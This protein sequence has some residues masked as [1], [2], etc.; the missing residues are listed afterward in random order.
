MSTIFSNGNLRVQKS[1]IE[2]LGVFANRDFTKGEIVLKWNPKKQLDVD[3]VKNIAESERR[4]LSR[5]GNKYVVLDSPAKYVN[6]SCTPNTRTVG[7]SDVATRDI[8]KNE[9]ITAQYQTEGVPVDFECRCG[10]KDC[11]REYRGF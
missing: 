3:G 7:Y 9:E 10:S 4:Y 5:V 8:T 1:P 2:G 6:H 11:R